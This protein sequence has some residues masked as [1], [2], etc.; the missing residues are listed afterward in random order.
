MTRR[1]IARES[2][3]RDL[4]ARLAADLCRRSD[5][6]GLCR[7]YVPV[8]EALQGA[9]LRWLAEHGPTL[10]AAQRALWDRWIIALDAC[11]A[12]FVVEPGHLAGQVLLVD[13][14]AAGT[15]AEIDDV[16]DVPP[17]LDSDGAEI[18]ADDEHATH[19]SALPPVDAG[20]ARGPITQ[21]LLQQRRQ[22]RV[23]RM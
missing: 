12:E 1:T 2:T 4:D 8:G 16:A 5:A 13:S 20:L 17:L 23:L 21:G 6:A 15:L 14:L 22:R 11:V 10:T 7:V 9:A 18:P 19:H 3:L